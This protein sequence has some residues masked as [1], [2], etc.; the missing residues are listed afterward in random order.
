VQSFLKV[1]ERLIKTGNSS[2]ALAEKDKLLQELRT[3]MYHLCLAK[4]QK[5]PVGE[6]ES[7]MQFTEYSCQ[8]IFIGCVSWLCVVHL[9]MCQSGILLNC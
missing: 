5:I 8:L 4:D 6:Q 9:V 3:Y 7:G 1:S 2:V